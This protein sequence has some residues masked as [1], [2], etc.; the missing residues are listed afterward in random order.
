MENKV[1]K[2][3]LLGLG[4]VGTGVFKMMRTQ[5]PEMMHKIGA[6]LEIK[7]IL[8]RNIE[9]ASRKVDDVSVLTTNWN[10]II[11]DPEIQIVIEVMGGLEPAGTYIDAALRAGKHVVTANKDLIAERGTELIDTAQSNHRDLLFEAA[12]AGGIPIIAPLLHSLKA[13]Y[14]DEIMG[15][16]NGTTNY[17]L[18]K[19]TAEGMDYQEALAEAQELGYA[20]ADPTADVEGLDAGRKVAIMAS[21][22][23]H[24]K[25]T[26]K[27]V[28]TEGI[29]GLTSKDIHY[30]DAF[31]TVVKLVGVAKNTPEGIEA[32]VHPLMLPKDHPLA[33]VSGSFNA[34]FL[35]GDA[36]DDVMFYGRGAGELPTASAI[37]GDV[38]DI[39]TDIAKGR[40]SATAASWYLD[41]PIKDINNIISRYYL[42]MEVEDKP[43]VLA[44]IASVLGNNSVSIE[45]IVQKAK[46]GD[47][48][49]IMVITNHVKESHLRD[50]L[51]TFKAMSIVKTEPVLIRVY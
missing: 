14:I 4:T 3:A 6:Q 48:A 35:H 44:T 37:M 28:Y 11:E 41:L 10:E 18:S 49:E 34:V 24:S 38:F 50:A 43:G 23:F 5:K 32:R 7:K 13:N 22:A 40:E 25:V 12:V 47:N 20:E 8:V 51:L 29:S 33:S 27:D 30:A 36:V 46:T 9:K 17:M 31:G 39:A 19:M 1:I 21:L 42:R 2:V 15:I 16:V 26:F 45:Q